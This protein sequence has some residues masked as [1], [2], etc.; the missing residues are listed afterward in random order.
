[1]DLASDQTSEKKLPLLAFLTSEVLGQVRLSLKSDQLNVKGLAA[2][3]VITDVGCDSLS[4]TTEV[5]TARAPSGD[6]VGRRQT[7]LQGC[8]DGFCR[9]R[10][11][12]IVPDSNGERSARAADLHP[13]RRRSTDSSVACSS[14]AIKRLI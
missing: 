10:G 12:C 14:Q 11:R 8:R 7:Y 6:P 9:G 3:D 4:E 1:M 5:L 2:Y 13:Y